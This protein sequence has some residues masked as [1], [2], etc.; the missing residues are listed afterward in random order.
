MIV[1]NPWSKVQLTHPRLIAILITILWLATEVT[2]QTATSARPFAPEDLFRLRRVGVTAWAPNGLF[3]TIEFSKD[4]RWLDSVP[5]NDLSLLDVKTR[6]LRVLSPKSSGLIGFF[7][8]VWS[9]DSRRVA[10]LSVDR[11]ATVRVWVWT[12][13][14]QAPSMLPN[15]DARS[16]QSDTPNRLDR[17]REASGHGLGTRRRSEW[18]TLRAS[19]ERAKCCD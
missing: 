16:G 12:V 3:A 15:L 1:S 18:S 6:S 11:E 19:L 7:N 14:T 9:P 17:Q 2:G 10:F 13:G 4:S 5:T 8:A